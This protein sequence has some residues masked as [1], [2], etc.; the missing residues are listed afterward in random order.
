MF[1]A[2][3]ILVV[4]LELVKYL[5][6]I[7]VFAGSQQLTAPSTACIVNLQKVNI[8]TFFS[9]LVE[10]LHTTTQA[11]DLKLNCICI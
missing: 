7:H 5:K 11:K 6:I 4:G 8:F 1:C 9:N 2:L 10:N 3:S